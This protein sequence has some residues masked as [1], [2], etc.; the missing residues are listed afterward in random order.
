MKVQN[1]FAQASNV[2]GQSCIK[3]IAF[4]LHAEMGAERFLHALPQHGGC[5]LETANVLGY[6]NGSGVAC[7]CARRNYS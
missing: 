1:Y 5:K 7:R 3:S 2:K 6:S 4:V